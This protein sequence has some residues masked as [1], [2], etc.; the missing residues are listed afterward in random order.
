MGSLKE[1]AFRNFPVQKKKHLFNMLEGDMHAFG[2]ASKV[3]IP[4]YENFEAGTLLTR[5]P[6]GG[7]VCMKHLLP[8]GKCTYLP[9]A[10]KIMLV[11]FWFNDWIH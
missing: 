10:Y 3:H 5:L 6:R 2:S 11:N 1:V 7:Y 4:Q 8:S 9:L